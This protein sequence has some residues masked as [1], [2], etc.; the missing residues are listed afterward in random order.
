MTSMGTGRAIPFRFYDGQAEITPPLSHVLEVNDTNAYLAAGLAGLGI[1]QAPGFV[2]QAAIESGKLVPFLQEW[3]TR[4][5]PV[6]LIYA[7]NRYLSA[8]VRVFIDWVVA[9]FER[10]SSLKLGSV[11]DS[12]TFQSQ[13]EEGRAS[14]SPR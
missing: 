11:P 7:P 12:Q 5:M 2:V 8:K 1:I 10:H 14:A 6:H 3:R 4:T 13:V 9:L